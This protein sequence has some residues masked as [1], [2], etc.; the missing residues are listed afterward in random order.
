M[1]PS[2][3]FADDG[4]VAGLSYSIILGD[5]F[6]GIAAL[7]GAKGLVATS[8]F[9]IL[10]LSAFVLLPLALLRDLSS[11]AVGSV[12][13]TAGTLYTVRGAPPPC[14]PMEPRPASPQGSHA[15][16]PCPASMSPH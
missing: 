7:A 10:G 12:V 4:Q 13:G 16:P 14:Q 1:T 11:L 15:F 5:S 6:A 9:W 2:A 8:N 3:L